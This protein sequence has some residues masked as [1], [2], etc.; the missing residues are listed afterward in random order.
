MHSTLLTALSRFG[1]PVFTLFLV[2]GLSISTL[3]LR[4]AEQLSTWFCFFIP[5]QIFL[6]WIQFLRNKSHVHI[7]QENFPGYKYRFP[8]LWKLST[9]Q[10]TKGPYG[11]DDQEAASLKAEYKDCFSCDLHV[12][13]R[14]HHCPY[15]RRCIY[16]LDH[17]CFFLG[18]CVGRNNLRYFLVF[19]L[20][21]AIGCA[22]GV[23]HLMMEMKNYR[24]IPSR[25]TIYY[26]LPFSLVM[27]FVEKFPLWETFYV[28]LIDFGTGAC[29]MCAFLFFYGVYSVLIG[30]TPYEYRRRV[31]T[32]DSNLTPLQRF[33]IVFGTN[34]FL[35]F[36]FPFNPFPWDPK[37]MPAYKMLLGPQFT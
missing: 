28:G 16:I 14:S 15:C 9:E 17:H 35:L 2:L 4:H 13:T 22:V 24:A 33:E 11:L 6:N 18:H 27:Y 34:G 20:Y 23:Y 3:Q 10:T 31:K 36:L 7:T 21:A 37:I 30:S 25:D 5:A 1:P 19:C 8:T 26:F 12:P 29:G 32:Q